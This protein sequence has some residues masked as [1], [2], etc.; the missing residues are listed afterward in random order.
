MI[1]LSVCLFTVF[2]KTSLVNK[3][4]FS[5]LYSS[6]L[7]LPVCASSS[8]LGSLGSLTELVKKKWDPYSQT[9]WE[10]VLAGLTMCS[11]LYGTEVGLLLPDEHHVVV[12]NNLT[13]ILVYVNRIMR[14]WKVSFGVD[15]WR[16]LIQGKTKIIDLRSK[17]CTVDQKWTINISRKEKV[18]R[19]L[20]SSPAM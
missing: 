9:P 11:K 12:P 10:A 13:R 4:F 14:L 7:T 18:E 8:S 1:L 3:D 5:H 15:L 6:H 19:E 2:P 20:R 17:N 16:V